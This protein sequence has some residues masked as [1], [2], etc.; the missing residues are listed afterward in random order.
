MASTQKGSVASHAETGSFCFPHEGVPLPKGD[1]VPQASPGVLGA[2]LAVDLIQS[3]C[4]ECHSDLSG[5]KA[6]G[7]SLTSTQS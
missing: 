4:T 1:P 3:A 7:I 5:H 2:A 6:D